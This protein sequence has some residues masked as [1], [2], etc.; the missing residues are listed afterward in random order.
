MK[1]H[2]AMLAF[3]LGLATG[4]CQNLVQNPD[5]ESYSPCPV[6]Q[7]QIASAVGWDSF[8][9]SCDYYHSCAGT[10]PANL[11]G[12]QMPHSGGGYAGII[13]FC[14]AGFY[15]EVIGGQLVSPLIIGQKYNISFYVSL[16]IE[17]PNC[18]FASNK[19]G[20]KFTTVAYD[21]YTNKIPINNFATLHYD[22]I[23]TDTTNWQLVTGSFIADS[24]YTFIAIGNFFDDANTD[25]IRIGNGF[26]LPIYAYYYIDDVSVI[27][28]PTGIESNNFGS[29]TN[30]LPNPFSDQLTINLS[31]N[32]QA[33]ITIYDLMAKK[34]LLQKFT[35]SVTLNT[36]Q[37][38]KGIYLYQVRNIRGII[39]KGKVLKY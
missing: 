2:L 19:I 5:F 18:A 12:Y 4:H 23:I 34:I 8:S 17:P 35:T 28:D 39:E 6:G 38:S 32:E 20:V 24:A 22:T 1:R 11:V 37:F 3:T 14:K 25:T 26:V 21:A 15:R 36:S 16:S 33:E 31:K 9:E 29:H 7:A 10:T 27:A 30:I 13:I